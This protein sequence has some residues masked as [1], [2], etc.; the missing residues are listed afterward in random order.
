MVT[1]S[2]R[3]PLAIQLALTGRRYLAGRW[4][5]ENILHL[6]FSFVSTSFLHPRHLPVLCA[7]VD[8]FNHLRRQR[9][10]QGCNAPGDTLRAARTRLAEQV[11]EQRSLR[12]MLASQ[13]V[14]LRSN[15]YAQK[16]LLRYRFTF[17]WR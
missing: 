8:G 5:L 2:R 16:E 10:A 1:L 15:L 3:T 14:L 4:F 6:I 12:H 9:R 11:Y 7:L 13:A 17:H